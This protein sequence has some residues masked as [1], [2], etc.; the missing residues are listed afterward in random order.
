MVFRSRSHQHRSQRTSAPHLKLPRTGTNAAPK[1][2]DPNLTIHITA[3]MDKFVSD[4][5]DKLDVNKGK[6]VV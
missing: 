5:F 3:N 6:R 2:T 1:P 4:A